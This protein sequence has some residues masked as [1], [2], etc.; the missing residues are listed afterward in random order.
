MWFA[1]ICSY[2]KHSRSPWWWLHMKLSVWIRGHCFMNF[3]ILL[4]HRKSLSLCLSSSVTHRHW[5]SRAENLDFPGSPWTAHAR[6]TELQFPRDT[7][8]V[9]GRAPAPF[10]GGVESHQLFCIWHI[11]YFG[12][13][14][15]CRPCFAS[16]YKFCLIFSSPRA[17][18]GKP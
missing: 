5:K 17:E 11:L 16:S 18:L 2:W 6:P 4:V 7:T 1:I 13:L 15:P 8:R 12:L 10:W 9:S 14:I 3:V